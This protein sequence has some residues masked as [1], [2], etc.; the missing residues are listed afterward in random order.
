M[1]RAHKSPAYQDVDHVS[2]H[3]GMGSFYVVIFL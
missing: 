3:N 1:T 2:K